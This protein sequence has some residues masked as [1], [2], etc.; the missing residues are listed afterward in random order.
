MSEDKTY[1]K[2]WWKDPSWIA[3]L[4]AVLLGLSGVGVSIYQAKL[5]R[6][7]QRMSVWPFLTVI[8]DN[9]ELQGKGVSRLI[10]SNDGVGPALVQH[11]GLWLDDRP[12]RSWDELFNTLDPARQ[13]DLPYTTLRSRVL[14]AG[15]TIEAVIIDR[16]AD[17]TNL[18]ANFARIR[19]DLCY[20]SVY[21]E[22]YLLRSAATD[23]TM[24]V[25]QCPAPT[26]P[27]F[28]N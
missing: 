7:Q 25:Q 10:I 17:I 14:P 6:E 19:L 18:Q 21:E 3:A 2:P 5:M 1:R 22:C 4:G 8:N 24:P 16:T 20:C 11:V 27:P 15:R 13:A 23:V 12:M 9:S 28:S 26:N